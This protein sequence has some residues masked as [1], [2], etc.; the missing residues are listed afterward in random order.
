MGWLQPTIFF[1]KSH[2]KKYIIPQRFG[3][4]SVKR[5]KCHRIIG[6]VTVVSGND[7]PKNLH[8]ISGSL[9]QGLLNANSLLSG[10]FSFLHC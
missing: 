5:A 4:Q 9:S 3:L 7:W 8:V 1:G 10:V 2:I 6:P